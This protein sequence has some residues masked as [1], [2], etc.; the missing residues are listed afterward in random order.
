MVESCEPDYPM[1]CELGAIFGAGLGLP[2]GA[3]VL[4]VAVGLAVHGTKRRA[5]SALAALL[6]VGC[7]AYLIWL[8]IA[9]PNAFR[10][11]LVQNGELW[12]VASVILFVATWLIGLMWSR[13]SAAPNA[14]SES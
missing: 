11:V 2:I 5:M 1:L 8:R 12:V 14:R 3:I 7:V 6:V 13:G 9:F 10:N 4:G